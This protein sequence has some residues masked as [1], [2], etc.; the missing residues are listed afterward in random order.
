LGIIITDKAIDVQRVPFAPIDVSRDV[1]VTRAVSTAWTLAPLL[2]AIGMF[3]LTA[4]R[5]ARPPRQRRRWF[6]RAP[7]TAAW[8]EAPGPAAREELYGTAP[9]VFAQPGVP[10]ST[11]AWKLLAIASFVLVVGAPVLLRS[12]L[13]GG[14]HGLAML[15]GLTF[16]AAAATGLS[17][18]SRG[19]KLFL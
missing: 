3:R 7:G 15:L 5:G 6:A 13:R 12:L 1:L 14:G 18:L 16:V 19:G 4:A 17:A 11:V 10:R 2:A 8:P 9:T